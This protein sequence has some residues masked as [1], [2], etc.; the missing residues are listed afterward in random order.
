MRPVLSALSL[1]LI[2]CSIDRA[3]IS[4]CKS[5]S[6]FLSVLYSSRTPQARLF[7]ALAN[8]YAKGHTTAF[9]CLCL[10]VLYVQ[11][12]AEDE[13]SWIVPDGQRSALPESPFQDLYSGHVWNLTAHQK[14][15]GDC[16]QLCKIF[17]QY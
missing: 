1:M 4:P 3:E 9:L 17:I 13:T 5:C 15:A 12:Q 11:R 8:R 10:C 14:R 16:K 2:L 6:Q 7:V